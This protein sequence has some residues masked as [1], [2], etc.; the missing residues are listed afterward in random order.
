MSLAWAL[1][2]DNVHG[3]HPSV[4]RAGA[5]KFKEHGAIVSKTTK[6]HIFHLSMFAYLPGG[7]TAQLTDALNSWYAHREL[8]PAA[9]LP[10]IVHRL[11]LDWITETRD[12]LIALTEAVALG[13]PGDIS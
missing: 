13:P 4:I 3:E 10:P 7:T 5:L 2:L 8:D 1:E 9:A 12:P 11:M 6:D